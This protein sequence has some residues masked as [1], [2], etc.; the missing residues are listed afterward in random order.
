MI[1]DQKTKEYVFIDSLW[2]E[3]GRSKNIKE[4]HE[5]AVSNYMKRNS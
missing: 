2:N 1:W 3:Y 5:M 4:G